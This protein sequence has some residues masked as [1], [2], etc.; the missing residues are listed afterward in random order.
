MNFYT[1]L[2]KL[3]LLIS[4]EKKS[5]SF[6]P[7]LFFMEVRNLYKNLYSLDFYQPFL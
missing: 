1:L 7:I 3:T 2:S 6:S 4:Q 5:K